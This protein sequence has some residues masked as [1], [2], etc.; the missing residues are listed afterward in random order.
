LQAR[1]S[2]RLIEFGPI[3]GLDSTRGYESA[4]EGASYYASRAVSLTPQN[5][6]FRM[7]LAAAREMNGDLE[8]AEAAMRSAVTL[9]P[10]H[11]NV[12]WRLAN[13]LA[14]SGKLDQAALELRL[15]NAAD[16]SRLKPSLDLLWQASE[17]NVEI[18][19]AIAG[20]DPKSLLILAQYLEQQ[21]HLD[22]AVDI[23]SRIDREALVALPESGQFLET[24]VSAGASERARK[25]WNDIFGSGRMP[26]IWNG[27]FETPIREG[28]TQ[29]DWKL[30]QSR[31]AQITIIDG[32]SRSGK[33]SLRIAYR[34]LDTTQLDSEIRQMIL[35]RPGARYRLTC[36]A[37]A[38]NLLTP[39]GP[40]IVV[41][42]R[43]SETPIAASATLVSGSYD[44]RQLTLN[45][46][47]P[48]DAHTV[49]VSVKQTP[50]LSYV[51]GTKGIVWFDDF[52]LTEQ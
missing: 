15:L 28:F 34:G 46:V 18:L 48:P 25:L 23:V 24:L 4:A 52:D 47:A 36:Y 37:K 19:S 5:Y 26:L 44:W 13:T 8:G 21:D 43:V 6:E 14:R 16:S 42:G 11:V 49:T 27:G 41:T 20:K 22:V 7:L 17:G 51:D 32:T 33:Y 31:Y 1:A 35:T 9:A 12:R 39:D 50:R 45:F 2:A 38:E 10:Q 29:F 30:S 3:A 40:Q